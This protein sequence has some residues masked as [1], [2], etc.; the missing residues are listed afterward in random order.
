MT[1]PNEASDE[2]SMESFEKVRITSNSSPPSRESEE[3]KYRLVT[4]PRHGAE[5]LGA[6][7]E[8]EEL[9]GVHRFK[10]LAKRAWRGNHNGIEVG[11]EGGVDA[12]ATNM[13]CIAH[14]N[15]YVLDRS[16][17]LTRIGGKEERSWGWSATS[18]EK[19]EW[20]RGFGLVISALKHGEDQ[21]DC[22]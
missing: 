4:A 6:W 14:L 2:R 12:I 10:D 15:V 3:P 16:A 19:P 20:S 9:P 18:I 22:R 13:L 11:V 5:S 8:F 7:S 1:E 21:P 17:Q